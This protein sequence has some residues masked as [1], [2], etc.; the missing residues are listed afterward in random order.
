[1]SSEV[2]AVRQSRVKALMKWP[3]GTGGKAR[4]PAGGA[5]VEARQAEEEAR[6]VE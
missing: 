6:P 2:F 5:G 1:L 3:E 4:L